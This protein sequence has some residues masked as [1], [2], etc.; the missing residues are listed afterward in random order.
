MK[1]P[2]FYPHWDCLVHW[3]GVPCLGCLYEAP[4]WRGV[5]A[6]WLWRFVQ[7]WRALY[8]RLFA[9]FEYDMEEERKW[10]LVR[11][12]GTETTPTPAVTPNPNPSVPGLEEQQQA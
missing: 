11:R 7:P 2:I 10:T 4:E 1:R 3:D 8:C 6:Y 9:R 12:E 5:G